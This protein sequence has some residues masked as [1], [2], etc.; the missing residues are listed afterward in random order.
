[1]AIRKHHLQSQPIPEGYQIFEDQIPVAGIDRRRAAA[2]HFIQGR[3]QALELEREPTNPK[4]TN[5]IRVMAC[6]RGWFLRRR[7]MIGYLPRSIAEQVV[8]GGFWGKLKPR[9]AMTY[10]NDAGFVEVVFQLLG[11]KGEKYG[12]STPEAEYSPKKATFNY[13][14]RVEQLKSEKKH[15]E[16]IELL[17]KLV[18]QEEAQSA[19]SRQGVAPW[20]YEQLAIIYRKEKRYDLEVEV[21]ERYAAQPHAPGVGPTKLS[22]RLVKAK[23]LL[24]RK[25]V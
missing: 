5:A 24:S 12:F 19:T 6:H 25:R 16:A 1:V 8:E 10:L 15:S 20:Y 17:L 13:V 14:E 23:D 18:A 2:K 22:E 4:D 3:E 9:L 7:R 21:L 11:P